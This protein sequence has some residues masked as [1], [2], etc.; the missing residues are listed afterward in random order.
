MKLAA[1]RESIPALAKAKIVAATSM[2]EAWK[3]L[4]LDY[5]NMQEV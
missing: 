4:D 1:L 3:L 2:I 5:G